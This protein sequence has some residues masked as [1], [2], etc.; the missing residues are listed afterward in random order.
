[1]NKT[2]EKMFEIPFH[3][4]EKRVIIKKDEKYK[5]IRLFHGNDVPS[6]DEIFDFIE[7]NIDTLDDLTRKF[8]YNSVNMTDAIDVDK[9]QLM[10]KLDTMDNGIIAIQQVEQN[11]K[12]ITIE[13]E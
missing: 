10:T 4:S 6:N 7:S 8:E 5:M 12:V 2:I 1:M 9:D 11:Y 13:E 3:G